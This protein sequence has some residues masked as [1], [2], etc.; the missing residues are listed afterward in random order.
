MYAVRTSDYRKKGTFQRVSEVADEYGE[1]IG[2]WADLMDVRV[3]IEGIT[4][5]ERFAA[6]QVQSDT[7]T[8]IRV[9]WNPTLDTLTTKDRFK[10]GSVIYDI[11]SVINTRQENKEITI[12]AKIHG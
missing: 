10:W 11:K 8:R 4:G 12:M 1:M 6:Y 9:R 2:T 7:D 3:A 5:S